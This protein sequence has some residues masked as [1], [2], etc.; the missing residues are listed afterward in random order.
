MI[1]LNTTQTV[2][3]G[4]PSGSNPTVTVLPGA[5]TN[6]TLDFTTTLNV[7]KLPVPA[8]LTVTGL[9]EGATVG[10]N[11]AV[12]SQTTGTS[13]TLPAATTLVNPNVAIQLPSLT[14][15]NAPQQGSLPGWQ[16]TASASVLLS[17]LFLPF[18]RRMR[19]AGKRLRGGVMLAVLL[20][21]G[22]AATVGLTGCGASN[23]FLGQQ[24]QTYNVTMTVT[25][26]TVTRTSNLTLTVQ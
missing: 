25:A 2:N 10:V 6:V 23:G 22:L 19:S 11:P 15:T 7:T 9:P 5:A 12:W 1:D 20:M 18:S 14:A 16:K 17:L 13:W 8:V 26:G 21:A 3:G 24:Q 4:S